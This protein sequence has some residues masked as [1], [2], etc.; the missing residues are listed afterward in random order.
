[1]AER[2]HERTLASE[3]NTR[4]WALIIV[5]ALVLSSLPATLARAVDNSPIT[6][7]IVETEDPSGDLDFGSPA[8]FYAKITIG[9]DPTYETP[10]QDFPPEFGTGFIYPWT[11]PETNWV[12]TSYVDPTVVPTRIT[13]QLWDDD[14]GL[15]FGDDQADIKPGSGETL[16]IA[17]DVT[18]GAIT[19]DVTGTAGTSFDAEGTGGDR[20]RVRVLIELNDPNDDDLDGLLNGWETGGH[21]DG[22]NLPGLG[23]N[24]QRKDLFLEVDC[25]ANDG[26]GNGSF[27]DAADHVH[28][29][30]AAAV[31]LVVQAFA[32]APVANPDGTT[33]IQLHVDMGTRFGAGT[34]TSVTG[35]GGV[36]GTYGDI[37]AGG[38]GQL[39]NE[40][41]NTVLSL[42]PS[43]SNP[44]M[45]DVKSMAA[46]RADIFHYALFAH[47]ID[48]R[49]ASGDCTSGQGE[50]PGND[51][52]V[53]LGGRRDLNGDGVG[54]T[55]CWGEGPLNGVDDDGDGAT[56]E[57]PVNG[58]DDDG[59]CIAD[60]DGDGNL[61]DPGDVG[62]DEDGGFSIGNLNQL[63]GT[64]MHEF[65]HNLNLGH[66]GGD[67]L[68]NK[69]NYLSTMNYRN[70][71]RLLTS[72]SGGAQ[73]CGVPPNSGGTTTLPGGC[74]YSR[75][76]VNLNEQSPG[77][78]ECAGIDAG[79]VLNFGAVDFDASGGF[80]GTTCVPTSA[81]LI[82]VDVNNNGSTERLNGYDDWIS[83]YYRFR[84][85]DNFVDGAAGSDDGSFLDYRPEDLEDVQLFV[86]AQTAP[87]FEIALTGP[88]TAPNGTNVTL[89]FDVTN[90]G[91]GPAFDV[92]GSLSDPDGTE[93]SS[94][95][96]G[97]QQVGAMLSNSGTYTVPSDACPS[98]LSFP[99]TVSGTGLSML[100]YTATTEHVLEVLDIDPPEIEV[101]AS[102]N[103][104]WAPDH[105]LRQIVTNVTVTDR[106]DDDP[107]VALVSITSSDPENGIGDG[108]TR[109][110]IVG[111]DIGADDRSFSLRAERSRDLP[112]IY[113]ITYSATDESGNVA[114]ASTSVIVPGDLRIE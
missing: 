18:T 65:G 4:R 69:P 66:G 30:T 77:I 8:D 103:E 74:D 20:A 60:T 92:A 32:D 100:D 108:S 16:E 91:R 54:D 22:V 88:S 37:G 93:M 107:A 7:R 83:L 98:F 102:P 61:C 10:H 67:G 97:Q 75:V 31:E 63:A 19:G 40:A 13:I 14:S 38:G 25:L 82:N 33:G 73:F 62:V 78:D 71:L 87:E 6:V 111:A 105:K 48:T 46:N 42:N 50:L 95:S 109:P 96:A 53:S 34:V 9:D 44:T 3:P 43:S 39:I 17:V 68:N 41:G 81:N 90:K 64:V 26:D 24:P 79:G 27:T 94:V 104:L 59:D 29:P 106:C 28:C 99:A 70:L 36:T 110:D 114:F 85:L 12:T 47:Q 58:V 1:M 49:S 52:F 80:Q 35:L 5:G 2:A 51:F 11:V 86:D 113:T 45:W 101:S 112:R 72:S 57:D 84:D 21:P 89:A 15:A 23:A 55:P 76:V 56:D